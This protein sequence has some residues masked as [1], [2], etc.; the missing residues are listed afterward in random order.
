MRP[1]YLANYLRVTA[2]PVRQWVTRLDAGVERL[3]TR[4]PPAARRLS[5]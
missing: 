3:Q 4:R 1:S 2:P 5:S